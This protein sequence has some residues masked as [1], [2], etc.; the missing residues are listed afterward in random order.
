MPAYGG[1]LSGPG[2]LVGAGLHQEPLPAD[3]Q[4][5]QAER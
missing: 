4:M 2:N 3:I 5:V 1:I